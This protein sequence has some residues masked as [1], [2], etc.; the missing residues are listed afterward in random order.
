MG[1]MTMFA[2]Q[3]GIAIERTQRALAWLDRHL[4]G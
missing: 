2:Q 1:D 3:N 4:K